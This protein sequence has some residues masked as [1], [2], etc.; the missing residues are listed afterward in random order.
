MPSGL[1]AQT[2]GLRPNQ[3]DLQLD[4]E[5]GKASGKTAL[6]ICF[7]CVMR[8]EQGEK[9]VISL[10]AFTTDVQNSGQIE[11][12]AFEFSSNKIQTATW[13]PATE[14]LELLMADDV[15]QEETVSVNLPL[16]MRS[17]GVTFSFV[18]PERGVRATGNGIS[19]GTNAAAGLVI[20]QPMTVMTV[21]SFTT[22]ARMLYNPPR[23]GAI[24]Q[25][26]VSLSPENGISDGDVLVLHLPGFTQVVDAPIIFDVTSNAIFLGQVVPGIFIRGRWVAQDS[27]L[28]LT[29]KRTQRGQLSIKS[30]SS[31][32]NQ[33]PVNGLTRNQVGLRIEIISQVENIPRSSIT[34]SEAVGT[35]LQSPELRYLPLK[36]EA[37]LE[38]TLSCRAQMDINT[39]EYILHSLHLRVSPA[40]S[41]FC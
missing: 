3:G 21:G 18:I 26:S 25:I 16:N 35:F 39:G 36:V 2:A 31:A 1:T 6:L 8:I 11:V 28:I 14:T 27:L 5:P 33:L 37:P 41:G 29:S 38:I 4:F 10:P 17:M 20:G 32:Q 13:D 9:L 24:S 30:P 40:G 23:A 7:N 15:E 19:I 34:E 12:S 22:T